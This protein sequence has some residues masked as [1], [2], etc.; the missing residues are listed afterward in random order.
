MSVLRLVFLTE[1]RSRHPN[2]EVCKF[3]IFG[4]FQAPVTMSLNGSANSV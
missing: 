3:R 4:S 2:L 1:T